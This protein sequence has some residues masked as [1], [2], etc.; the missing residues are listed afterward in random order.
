MDAAATLTQQRITSTDAAATLTQKRGCH[1]Y[2]AGLIHYSATVQQQ[3]QALQV[4]LVGSHMQRSSPFL[5]V[6]TLQQH[7]HS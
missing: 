7:L 5:Q 4:A 2:I 3:Q 1:A 6:Q